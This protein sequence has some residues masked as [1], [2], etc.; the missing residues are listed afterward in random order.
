MNAPWMPS[1]SAKTSPLRDAPRLALAALLTLLLPS[2][3]P[4]AAAQTGTLFAGGLQF[5]ALTYDNGRL[6]WKKNSSFAADPPPRV[7]RTASGGGS[8]IH[9]YYRPAAHDQWAPRSRNFAVDPLGRVFWVSGNKVVTLAADALAGTAPTVLADIENATAPMIHIAASENYVYWTETVGEASEAGKIFRVRTNGTQ[10]GEIASLSG[11]EG[12]P[13][14]LHAVTVPSTQIG[15]ADTEV[16]YFMKANG[17]LVKYHL[18]TILPWT[19][20]QLAP[21]VNATD[22]AMGRLYFA[23]KNPQSEGIRAILSVAM[24][25]TTTITKDADI[26]PFPPAFVP[27]ITADSKGVYWQQVTDG[28]TGAIM[29]RLFTGATDSVHAISLPLPIMPPESGLVSDNQHLFWG[30][31]GSVMQTEIR[32]LPV[33]ASRVVF[34]LEAQ[35]IEVVQAIQDPGN[36]VPLV[37]NKPTWARTF[38]RIN[39]N[40]PS[41]SAVSTTVH[42]HGSRDGSLLPGSPLLAEMG[43]QL[44]L[45]NAPDRTNKSEGW[46]FRLPATWTVAGNVRLQAIV[47]PFNAPNELLLTNNRQEEFVEF[48]SRRDVVAFIY[49]LRTHQGIIESNRPEYGPVF[50]LARNLMP[51]ENLHIVFPRGPVI[52]EWQGPAPWTF[53]PYELSKDD[54]DSGWIFA[55]LGLR[56]VLYLAGPSGFGD[57]VHH[58]ALF[59]SFTNRAFNGIATYNGKLFI[60]YMDTG[61][62]GINRPRSAL[63][64]AHELGH[65]LGRKHVNYGNPADPDPGYPYDVSQISSGVSRHMGFDAVTRTPIHWTDAADLMSYGHLEGKYRWP[66]AYTWTAMFNKIGASSGAR[67]ARGVRSPTG[68]KL[69]VTGVISTSGAVELEPGTRLPDASAVA[70]ANELV[71][72]A[73]DTATFRVRLLNAG[74]T[75]LANAVAGVYDPDNGGSRTI[76][77]VIDEDT[78]GR[79]MQL[80]RSSAI[81]TPVASLA[82]SGAA[83]VT[84]ISGPTANAVAGTSLP[85]RWSTSAPEGP[86]TRHTVRYSNDGGASWRVIADG[87][88]VPNLDVPSAE[89]PGGNPGKAVIEILT[90]DGVR[91]TSARSASFTVTP[92]APVPAIA[93]QRKAGGGQPGSPAYLPGETIL[94]YGLATDMEDG[95]VASSGLTWNV[96]GPVARTGTGREYSPGSLRPGTYNISMLATDLQTRSASTPAATFTVLPKNVPAITTAPEIDGFVEEP[97]WLTDRQPVPIRYQS[98]ETAIV[99]LMRDASWFYVSV[100]GLR[101]GTNSRQFLAISTDTNNSGSATPQTGDRR[102]LVYA[103]G[104]LASE[105]GN[106]TAWVRDAAPAVTARI[107]STDAGWIVEARI[108]ISAVGG[109]NSQTIGL[110]IAHAGITAA[111]EWV[112]W[113]DGGAAT[114][115]GPDQWA[116]VI[117]TTAPDT[118]LDADS[119]TMS[120]SWELTN[121]GTAATTGSGDKDK[122]GQS[123][124]TEYHAGTDPSAASSRFVLSSV[125]VTPDGASVQWPS[126]SGFHYEVEASAT[127]N[128]FVSVSGSLAGT[129]SVMNFTVPATTAEGSS[130]LYIRLRSRRQS[131][132]W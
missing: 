35:P 132:G 112:H 59:N 28:S 79:S 10:R 29:R 49:P 62:T 72:E 83:P 117:L 39:G 97:Q 53:G 127:L 51:T 68:Q 11:S 118:G 44:A 73:D 111:N 13:V 40:T 26:P 42:L 90:S 20:T 106:G 86:N 75:V 12:G 63:T 77:A 37:A 7:Q 114:A 34:E 125:T 38:V 119:D 95:Q 121:L 78:D 100:T 96:T 120:D 3:V 14:S 46:W 1:F 31:G 8:V 30:H 115:S 89:L 102:F 50:N 122:D 6:Y 60:S 36:S 128:D 93:F 64:L 61:G 74:G 70:S 104:E 33:N 23:E 123:D 18:R 32:K 113:F 27:H 48:H 22:A 101:I 98:G 47:N 92:H 45:K 5:D 56:K 67:L 124:L 57:E 84:N 21:S 80:V 110:D 76:F 41:Q 55:K 16:V 105:Q 87:L 69:L 109:A 85:V 4:A 66:S 82:G 126:L 58:G 25:N 116:D 99:R 2:F 131:Q 129:G 81:S 108:P 54:D 65:N 15:L 94:L 9:S 91:T 43:D 19:Y 103:D 17:P 52:E 71:A 130:R 88:R 24:N 107:S